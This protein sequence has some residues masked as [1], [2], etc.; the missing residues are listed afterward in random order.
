MLTE[1]EY[2]KLR[3][4]INA[5]DNFARKNFTRPGG[6]VVMDQNA[7]DQA[8]SFAGREV[9]NADRS[10]VEYYEFI[11]EKPE[12]YFAYIDEKAGTMTNWMGLV[13]GNVQFRTKSSRPAITVKAVNGLTYKG[14]YYKSSGDYCRIKAIK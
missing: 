12:T 4:A 2:K 9:T 3:E 6:W 8:A 5:Y 7:K 13:L 10:E 11:T 14:T 1:K